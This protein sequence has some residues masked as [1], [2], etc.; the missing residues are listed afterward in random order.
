MSH[1]LASEVQL[2]PGL[3]MARCHNPRVNARDLFSFALGVCLSL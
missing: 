3:S 2:K 1:E